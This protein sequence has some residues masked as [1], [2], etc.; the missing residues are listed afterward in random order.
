MINW[1]TT[2]SRK[3]SGEK[4]TASTNN[5]VMNGYRHEKEW[6]WT[7]PLPHTIHKNLTQNESKTYYKQQIYKTLGSKHRS[8]PSWPWIGS[9]LLDM[10]PKAQSKKSHRMTSKSH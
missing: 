2:I 4:V 8:K 3:F 5:E 9:D 1:L 7:S 10:I 6:S